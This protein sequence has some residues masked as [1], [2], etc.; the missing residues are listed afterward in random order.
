[1]TQSANVDKVVDMANVG[2]RSHMGNH[3]A[4]RLHN[5]VR[6]REKVMR[7]LKKANSAEKVFKGFREYYNYVRPHMMF[8]GRAPAEI[9][10]TP[11]Q[12]GTNPWLDLM[13]QAARNS[14][15]R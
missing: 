4:E 10:A 2:I 3:R 5:T 15:N 1:M 13:R 7:H 14:R 11:I 12:L 9:A 6:E 8:E